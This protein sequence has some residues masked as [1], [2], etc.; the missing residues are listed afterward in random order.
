MR[1]ISAKI[2]FDY[3]AN[4]SEKKKSL[5]V[6]RS[7]FVYNSQPFMLEKYVNVIG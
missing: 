1:S 5:K 3:L 2:Y 4:K 6:E 7:H